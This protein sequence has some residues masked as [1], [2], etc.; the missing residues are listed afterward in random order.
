M[1]K[2]KLEAA[3]E[4]D[5]KAPWEEDAGWDAVD[6]AEDFLLGADEYGFMGLEVLNPPTKG[7]WRSGCGRISACGRVAEQCGH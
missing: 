4:E 2:R 1:G 6:V 3:P 5:V 7:A